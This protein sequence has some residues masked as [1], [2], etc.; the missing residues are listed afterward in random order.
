MRFFIFHLL[1]L[2]LL[3]ENYG[4]A[5]LSKPKKTKEKKKKTQTFDKVTTEELPTTT[6]LQRKLVDENMNYYD[7]L[8]NHQKYSTE[9]V[10]KRR[11]DNGE[12]L[13]YVTPWNNHGYDVAKR[14]GKFTMISPVWLQIKRKQRGIYNVEGTHDIDNGWLTE[15]RKKESPPKIVPRVLF[16]KWSQ[17]DYDS[18]FESED[19]IESMSKSIIDV[20]QENEMN[21]AVIEL[22][23]QIGEKNPKEVVHVVT[24]MAEMFHKNNMILI[25][26]VPAALN[27]EKKMTTNF[28]SKQFS[29]LVGV[30]DYFSLMTYDFSVNQGYPGPSSPLPWVR[31][32]VE[33]LDPEAKNRN[34]ILLGLNFYGNMYSSSGSSPIVGKQYLE[35]LNQFKPDLIWEKSVSEH[36]SHFGN[37]QTGKGILFYPT[38]K[39]IEERLKLAKKTLGTGI[40]IW[41]IGQGL[42]YFYDLL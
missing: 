23:S 32:C 5:T 28:D 13:A 30:V 20:L 3:L 16:D 41:E 2:N 36:Y 19:E 17:S 42:D 37:E 11:F 29:S 35:F 6:V 22:W 7:I 34:K 38:L 24:H 39:S 15:L 14:F 1:L 18:L 12:V 33:Y 26:V 25:L 8:E 21:G 31:A 4:D 10:N 9:H 40:S 27:K